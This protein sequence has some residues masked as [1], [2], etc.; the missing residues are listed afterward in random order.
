MRYSAERQRDRERVNL[1]GRVSELR[2]SLFFTGMCAASI[3]RKKLPFHVEEADIRVTAE[4]GVH[5]TAALR[6]KP[7]DRAY[8]PP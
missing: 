7:R 3:H 2:L 6:G 4:G 5:E 1:S 8:E